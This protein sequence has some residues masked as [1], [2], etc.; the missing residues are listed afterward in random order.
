MSHKR[1][2]V[3]F[4]ESL[5]GSVQDNS[6]ATSHDYNIDAPP[7]HVWS[8][9]RLHGIVASMYRGPWGTRDMWEDAWDRIKDG[10]EP[11]KEIPHCDI[12][13]PAE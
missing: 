4:V 9:D 2:V 13:L 6:D 3:A 5:G 12:C 7:G 11:C 10:V 8:S 1:K